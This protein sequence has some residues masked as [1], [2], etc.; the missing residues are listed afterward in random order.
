MVERN[1]EH[2]KWIG[3]FG[4]MKRKGALDCGMFAFH[5]GVIRAGALPV[6]VFSAISPPPNGAAEKAFCIKLKYCSIAPRV[7]LMV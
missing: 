1:A 2:A 6:H 7:W 4:G 5:A 3:K